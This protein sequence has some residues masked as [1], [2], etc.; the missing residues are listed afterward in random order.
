MALN[1][2]WGIAPPQNVEDLLN[3]TQ[4]AVPASSSSPTGIRP[5]DPSLAEYDDWLNELAGQD[6]PSC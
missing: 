4:T 2:L 5:F 6:F 1:N 3:G